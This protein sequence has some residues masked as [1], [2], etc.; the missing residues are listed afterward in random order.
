M[1]G[2]GT[3]ATV[4]TGIDADGDAYAIANEPFGEG[5]A[6]DG[7]DAPAAGRIGLIAPRS[8]RMPMTITTRT[9]AP[10]ATIEVASP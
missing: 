1:L 10:A 5:D 4:G 3:G 8:R 9:P 7:T 6:D 2:D